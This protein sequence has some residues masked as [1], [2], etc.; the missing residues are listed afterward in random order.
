MVNR[1]GRL[2][3]VKQ[4]RQSS[5]VPAQALQLNYNLAAKFQHNEVKPFS[6]HAPL[7]VGYRA[8]SI[9]LHHESSNH[10]A[11]KVDRAY[12]EWPFSSHSMCHCPAQSDLDCI[13]L[14][15]SMA[16]SWLNPAVSSGV[17]HSKITR[18]QQSHKLLFALFW[19]KGTVA[20]QQMWES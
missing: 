15:L 9:C 10:L 6:L 1:V 4:V 13:W 16:R 19:I 7:W 11:Y 2:P 17:K 8:S 5:Q 12:R 18:Q 14:H 3:K 20:Q